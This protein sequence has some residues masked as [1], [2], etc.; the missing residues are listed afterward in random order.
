MMPAL[1]KRQRVRI[2]AVQ[3]CDVAV[4][5]RCS[6]PGQVT[7]IHTYTYTHIHAHTHICVASAFMSIETHHHP[8]KKEPKKIKGKMKSCSNDEQKKE[9]KK[10]RFFFCHLVKPVS[11]TPHSGPS[12]G[13]F[14]LLRVPAWGACT[15][16]VRKKES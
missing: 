1:G 14:M 3:W 6:G 16:V 10:P 12:I 7:H 8:K 2:V 5:H 9:K 15:A 11:S 13:R 4:H